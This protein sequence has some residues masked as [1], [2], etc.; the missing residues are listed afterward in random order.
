MINKRLLSEERQS[1]TGLW[2][3][4]EVYEEVAAARMQKV[5]GAVLAS[6]QFLEEM[7]AVFGRV[8]EVYKKKG[9]SG[10][11]KNGRTVA[12][13]LSANAGLY[14]GI[15]D[16]TF[17]K[18]VQ[19]AQE[20]ECDLVVVGKL[21]V[22]MMADRKVNKL[23]NYYDFPDDSVD[24]ESLILVMRYLLQFEKIIVFYGKFRSI[25]AQ[26][27]VMTAVSGENLE[28]KTTGER[29]EYIFEPTIEEIAEVFEGQ[30][31]ASL[32]EQ[33][34]HESQLAKFASR[35]LNLDRSW[36]NIGKNLELV[37]RQELWWRRK[38]RNRKQLATMAGMSLW[39]RGGI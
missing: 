23:Y 7:L 4:V 5:R 17:E 6:R 21:G 29:V 20:S 16:K 11:A 36:E 39:W 18:F 27:P 37:E 24:P 2:S 8:R 3:L 35:L 22:K 13:F 30:I 19:F 10:L 26:D 28:V 33:T 25:L 38:T 32:F 1:L 9:F 34:L 14:G 12:V 31:L 15:V